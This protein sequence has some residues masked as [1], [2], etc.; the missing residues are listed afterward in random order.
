M[1]TLKLS[2]TTVTVEFGTWERTLVKR[3]SLT[4]PLAA[5]R[6]VTPTGNPLREAHGARN[7]L[8]VSGFAKVGVWGVFTGP[9][10][11][12]A[13]YRGQPGLRIEL[14]RAASGEQFDELVLSID[15]AAQ[16]AQQIS[17]KLGKH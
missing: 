14:D 15:N 1:A 7:G 13:A 11:L 9:R 17:Q 3:S 8:Q 2:G 4:V 5:V 12:V 6:R 16:I 10:Q